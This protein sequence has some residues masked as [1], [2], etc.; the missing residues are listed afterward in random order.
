MPFMN[1]IE[2]I[3]EIAGMN[4]IDG[5]DEIEEMNVDLRVRYV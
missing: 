2:E 3:D 1:E 5:V 4:E